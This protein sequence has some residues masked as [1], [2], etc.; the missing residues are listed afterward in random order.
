M[1]DAS[2]SMIWISNKQKENEQTE[3]DPNKCIK[4]SSQHAN[5]HNIITVKQ[6]TML[7]CAYIFKE[8]GPHLLQDIEEHIY[9][10]CECLLLYFQM[11]MATRT[12][13]CKMIVHFNVPTNVK[14]TCTH[15]KGTSYVRPIKV[16]LSSHIQK[17]HISLLQCLH[18]VRQKRDH[19]L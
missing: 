2:L 14:D 16:V 1:A 9:S 19:I 7:Q 3:R 17:C 12:L 8:Y 6:L 13:T 5:Y 11:T 15:W 10:S 18:N 4:Q